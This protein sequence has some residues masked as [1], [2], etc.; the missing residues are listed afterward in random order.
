MAAS[1]CVSLRSL[2]AS[3]SLMPRTRGSMAVSPAVTLSIFEFERS[4]RP[5]NW[6]VGTIGADGFTRRL[7][8]GRSGSGKCEKIGNHLHSPY[9]IRSEDLHCQPL[10]GI[11]EEKCKSL[12]DHSS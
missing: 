4:G 6:S 3:C 12:G 9:S 2:R 10:L 8:A 11:K 7:S 5:E 1:C